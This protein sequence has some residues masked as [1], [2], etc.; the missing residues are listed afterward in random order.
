MPKESPKKIILKSILGTN[1]QEVLD[2]SKA[3]LRL[4]SISIELLQENTGNEYTIEEV[5]PVVLSAMNVFKNKEAF[6]SLLEEHSPSVAGLE[7]MDMQKILFCAK[8]ESLRSLGWWNGT[9]PSEEINDTKFLMKLVQES[10]QREVDCIIHI[11][12][13]VLSSPIVGDSIAT[14]DLEK[15]YH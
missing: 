1:F 5:Y 15:Y 9:I 13:V 11:C 7:G 2:V 14:E 4:C 6:L 10:S 12:S 8:V 3:A